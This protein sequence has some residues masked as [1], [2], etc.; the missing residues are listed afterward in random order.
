[1]PEA[2]PVPLRHL[3]FSGRANRQD[4]TARPAGGGSTFSVY[5]QQRAAHAQKLQQELQVVEQEAERLRLDIDLY[6][7]IATTIVQTLPAAE[8]EI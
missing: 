1:M 3:D 4:Y 8:A 6:T 5:P 7:P 2:S